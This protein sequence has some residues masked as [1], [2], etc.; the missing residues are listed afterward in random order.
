MFGKSLLNQRLQVDDVK[1]LEQN[2]DAIKSFQHQKI[3]NNKSTRIVSKTPKR[4]SHDE[5]IETISLKIYRYNEIGLNINVPEPRIHSAPPVPR[6]NS[7]QLFHG[8]FINNPDPFFFCQ[9]ILIFGSVALQIACKSN[10]RS[11]QQEYFSKRLLKSMTI[12]EISTTV[13]PTR[14]TRLSSKDIE[15]QNLQAKQLSAAKRCQFH[16]PFLWHFLFKK[17]KL[18]CFENGTVFQPKCTLAVPKIFFAK[19]W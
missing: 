16:Q 2:S 4:D 5:N 9:M 3:T 1:N 13:I 15:K 12:S 18:F 8:D 17:A 19:F 7:A 14:M 6:F 10:L 11:T